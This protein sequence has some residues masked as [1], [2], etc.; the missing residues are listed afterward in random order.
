MEF[1]NLGPSGLQVSAI[2]LGCN[3]FGGRVDLEAARRVIDR[4]LDLGVTFFDTADVYGH[5]GGSE[6][7]LGQV[8]G[9]RRQRM[10]LATKFSHSMDDGGWLRGASRRYI[11]T[12]V[13]AS[14]QRLRTDWIDLYQLH[15]PDPATPI[16]ETLRALDDLIHQGKVRY[17]G[18]SNFAAWQ[19]ADAD[20]TARQ[21]GLNRFISCQNEYSLLVRDPERELLAAMQPRGLS[22]LPYFPLANGL[23]TGKYRRD[24]APPP[25][26]RLGASRGLKDRYWTER[27]WTLVERLEKFA[28]DH[29]H[30]LLELAFSW[31]LAH[32]AVAS[33]IAG[34][35]RP[36]QVEANAKM[37]AWKLS[38][39][40]LEE[41]DRLSAA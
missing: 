33:V 4:A 39:A 31:L 36:E 6:S 5:R 28:R 8:L 19:V 3:Q 26:T 41:I 38:A 29:G 27:N 37:G 40:E 30:T 18:N 15:D 25:D 24:Q 14:L 11:I 2:G 23:L 1:R 9:A 12:A 7:I 22:L 35:T 32:A 21:L 20:W 34:A 16:E 13:E 17:I 10:V